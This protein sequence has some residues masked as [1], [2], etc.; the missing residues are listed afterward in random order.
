MALVLNGKRMTF[1]LFKRKN[2][3][4]LSYKRLYLDKLNDE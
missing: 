3:F 1:E 2:D 4:S